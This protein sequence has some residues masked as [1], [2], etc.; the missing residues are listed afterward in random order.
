MAV[1]LVDGS[2]STILQEINRLLALPADFGE[3]FENIS[4]GEWAS[5]HIYLPQP[6]VQSAIT[7]PFMEAFF[8]F[9]EAAVPVCRAGHDGRC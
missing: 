5:L 4:F 8:G 6:D 1:A 7:P 3:E 2:P 9:A